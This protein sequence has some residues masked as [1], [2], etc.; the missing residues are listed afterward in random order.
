M[1]TFSVAAVFLGCCAFSSVALAQ[2][3]IEGVV[4]DST[5]S[6]LPGVEIRVTPGPVNTGTGEAVTDSLGRYRIERLPPASYE[7]KFRLP[8]FVIPSR[9]HVEILATA[10][11]ILNVVAHVA[12][13]P[14]AKENERCMTEDEVKVAIPVE[15]HAIWLGGMSYAALASAWKGLP[16]DSISLERSGLVSWPDSL[17]AVTMFRGGRAE[18]RV[19]NTFPGSD[20]QKSGQVSIWDYGRLCYLLQRLGFDRFAAGYVAPGYDAPSARISVRAGDREMSVRVSGDV[21]PVEFW[22][23]EQ[24]IDN[25]RRGINWKPK[26]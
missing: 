9:D 24:A 23:I 11:V 13:Y 17:R 20:V 3:T 14:D 26:E 15:Y 7:V 12:A 22:A 8:G 5:G 4:T 25:V 10:S 21:G 6:A 16:F 18:L 2:G 19:S 1:K